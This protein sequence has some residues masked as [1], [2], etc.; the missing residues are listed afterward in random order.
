MDLHA[1][2]PD[3]NVRCILVRYLAQDGY[4]GESKVARALRGV[5]E[6]FTPHA[7]INYYIQTMTDFGATL[8]A[9]NKPSCLLCPPV[10][11]CRTHLLGREADHPQPKSRKMLP[12][13]HTL[14]LIPANR[15]GVVPLYRRL[16][17]GPRGGLWSLLEPDDLDGLESLVAR[18][19]LTL[20]GCREPGG[21]THTFSRF[22]LAAEPWLVAVGG[23]PRA[24]AGGD[25][26]WYNLA[27]PPRLGP[28]VLVK[29]LPKYTEQKL[30]RGTAM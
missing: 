19:S 9:R 12:R 15:D 16:S 20:D 14:M 29:K 5:T 28:A 11:G 7:R 24:M 27:I 10:S 1:L 8:H 2:I 6:H 23:A 13:K 4:S 26:F 22:Q 30:G 21:L 25:R 17:S 18:H 3:G